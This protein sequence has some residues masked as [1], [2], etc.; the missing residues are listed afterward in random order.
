MITVLN[1]MAWIDYNANKDNAV[2]KDCTIRAL[3]LA[4]DIPYEKV[5]KEFRGHARGEKYQFNTKD[6]LEWY[7]SEHGYEGKEPFVLSEPMTVSEFEETHPD[8]TYLLLTGRDAVSGPSYGAYYSHIVCCINGN[9]YDSWNSENQYVK[10]VCTVDANHSDQITS[11]RYSKEE[12]EYLTK[13]VLELAVRDYLLSRDGKDFNLIDYQG[14]IIYS[15]N[16]QYNFYYTTYIKYIR[17]PNVTCFT[18]RCSDLYT[19]TIYYKINTVAAK[20][21]PIFLS[22]ALKQEAHEGTIVIKFSPKMNNDDIG[23]EIEKKVPS[24]IKKLAKLLTSEEEL[25]SKATSGSMWDE[26][27]LLNYDACY[28]NDNQIYKLLKN[29]S[30]GIKE[31]VISVEYSSY[32]KEWDVMIKP[33]PSIT[34]FNKIHLF[35][36]NAKQIKACYDDYMKEVQEGKVW[37]SYYYYDFIKGD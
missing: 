26:F 23:K 7:I 19:C 37:S 3:S 2:R 25:Y 30:D 33:D 36:K 13:Q 24:G 21:T 12:I 29:C 11:E 10:Y 5:S 18:I 6:N 8:G 31:N 35:G 32:N 16:T 28:G 20:E 17:I 1:E 15:D 14:I 27:P 4:Y 9:V 22:S 34:K